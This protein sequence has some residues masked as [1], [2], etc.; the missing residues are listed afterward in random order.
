MSLVP[1]FERTDIFCAEDGCPQL[2]VSDIKWN[3]G[4]KEWT[5]CFIKS[6]GG[7]EKMCTNVLFSLAEGNIEGLSRTL[8]LLSLSLFVSCGV[9][10]CACV[11][12]CV[13]ANKTA[14]FCVQAKGVFEG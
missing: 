9:K 5:V 13:L 2:D 4:I 8:F 10:N 11:C 12:E 6:Q 1:R 7:T 14:S 3:S